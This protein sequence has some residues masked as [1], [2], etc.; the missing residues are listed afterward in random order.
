MKDVY[1]NPWICN[2]ALSRYLKL[3]VHRNVHRKLMVPFNLN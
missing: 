2:V 1:K 3:Y